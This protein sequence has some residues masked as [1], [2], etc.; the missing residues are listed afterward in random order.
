MV[1][2]NSSRK[3]DSK[4]EIDG[5]NVQETDRRGRP[6]EATQ[7]DPPTETRL[8]RKKGKKPEDASVADEEQRSMDSGK[9]EDL[10]EEQKENQDQET[11][12]SAT[13]GDDTASEVEIVREVKNPNVANDIQEGCKVRRHVLHGG[14]TYIR[15]KAEGYSRVCLME[16]DNLP[17]DLCKF[18]DY[19]IKDLRKAI[20][21][22]CRHLHSRPDTF[23]VYY[24][25]YDDR[26]PWIEPLPDEDGI[27]RWPDDKDYFTFRTILGAF[28]LELESFILGKHI[29]I[30]VLM[31]KNGNVWEFRD[32]LEME[33]FRWATPY[34][35][36]F[37]QYRDFNERLEWLIQNVEK[38]NTG[39]WFIS[40]VEQL[41]VRFL[42]REQ[43]VKNND[44]L[45][46]RIDV[47]KQH[48][49]IQPTTRGPWRTIR[50]QREHD[51][52]ETVVSFC[53]YL[54]ET[55]DEQVMQ[56]E[57]SESDLLQGWYRTPIGPGWDNYDF[58]PRFRGS[59]T[60]GPRFPTEADCIAENVAWKK[61]ELAK[62]SKA[63][64]NRVEYEAL[65]TGISDDEEDDDD[66]DDDES[67][68]PP[69]DAYLISK[70]QNEVGLL[71]VPGA[72][73]SSNET[74]YM[75]AGTPHLR[76]GFEFSARKERD[77]L[78]QRRE[79]P[80]GRVTDPPRFEE[81]PPYWEE[82]TPE[83]ERRDL[84][85]VEDP[86]RGPEDPPGRQKDPPRGPED[87]R[88]RRE[89]PP[90]GPEDPPRGRR[91]PPR[92]PEDPPRQKEDPPRG[93]KDPLRR[94]EDPPRRQ[95]DPPRQWE[96]PP[97]RWE[98]PPRRWED[99][100]RRW[101]D[102]PRHR[103][104]PP[105]HRED[106][107]RFRGD[108]PRFK[109]DPPR[110][111]EDPPRKK[112]DPRRFREDPPRGQEDPLEYLDDRDDWEED[113]PRWQEDPPRRQAHDSR[114]SRPQAASYKDPT[115]SDQWRQNR[116]NAG[117]SRQ[118]PAEVHEGAFQERLPSMRQGVFDSDEAVEIVVDTSGA[119]KVLMEYQEW[120]KV[121][122]YFRALD[123][124]VEHDFNTRF[125]KARNNQQRKQRDNTTRPTDRDD[126]VQ[127]KPKKNKTSDKTG[128]IEI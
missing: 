93:L 49:G 12:D 110:S 94:R 109:E 125:V 1:K 96:D 2:E 62:F 15:P 45:R 122:D 39:E 52:V 73:S 50:N 97:R 123:K 63:V 81:D 66:E 19:D 10:K 55:I 24:R 28:I 101:E 40:H 74:V 78:K 72:V 100:P 114:L 117:S 92:G 113:P 38:C 115:R 99:P 80:P 61:Q 4:A 56:H 76:V 32:Y 29:D 126:T 25:P 116:P 17:K 86:P 127:P 13:K 83:R 69:R 60:Q 118:T 5:A 111:R 44:W 64:L 88:R 54:K 71:R 14:V 105:R 30:A 98:D 11:Q 112:E 77:L 37:I 6:R 107:P 48:K 65:P 95:E 9:V 23:D 22:Y 108:P 124:Y 35:W 75:A 67:Y 3:K 21:D 79:D 89:D 128:V 84:R 102:P 58:H 87:P 34:N 68:K 57:N 42:A 46:R 119:P 36:M 103:E 26:L 16:A 53:D 91:D 82:E 51:K 27:K 7:A 120:T 47:I 85:G 106:P 43:V 121:R 90:R 33:V 70:P 20:K 59:T 18:E 8:K 31:A 104:D 41:A